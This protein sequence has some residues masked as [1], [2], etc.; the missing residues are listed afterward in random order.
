MDYYALQERLGADLADYHSADADPHP[1]VKAAGLAGR[2]AALAMHGYLKASRYDVVFS[3]GENVGIP[4]A[5]LFALRRERPGHVLIGHRLSPR[6]KAPFLRALHPQMDAIFVYASTQQ[7]YGEKILRIPGAKL[8]LI[9]FHADSR[10]YH[11]KP[12]ASTARRIC[13]A[14]LELRDYPTL[15][16]AVRGLDVEVCVAAASP[17]SKR[18]NET[19][20]RAL[21]PNVSVRGYAY[22][23]LR[24][25]YA[26][27]QVVVVPLYENDFQA[28]VTTLLE[29]MAMGKAVIVSRTA[30]QTDVVEH[31]V[32]G[33]YV[34]P[35]D[36][37]AL[38]DAIAHLLDHP[39]D[40]ARLGRAARQTIE[41]TM[42]LSQWA[43][44]I[45]RTVEETGSTVAGRAAQ[46][47]MT[48]VR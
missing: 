45:S 26:S 33:L 25:L 15:I 29:G 8:H 31:G 36:P 7:R 32:N 41:S 5:A 3:N 18:R 34:P 14:G 1:L 43:D 27:S 24:D 19:T 37:R 46:R 28:G 20:G 44:R 9:P 21:P 39:D 38:R 23:D 13:S 17:W 22:P 47:R 40:A 6:K 11:P 2:D 4:L 42:T 12:E 10:F 35:G 16:E 30:G 48:K